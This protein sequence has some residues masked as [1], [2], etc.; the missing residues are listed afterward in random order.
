MRR[1]VPTAP[2]RVLDAP[3]LVDDYYLNLLDWSCANQVAIALEQSV[4]IWNAS[5]GSVANLM[6]CGSDNYV[7]SVRWSGDGAYLSIG[8]SD[9]DVQIW[10][11]DEQT[12]LRSMV[13]HQ[14]R[15]GVM[16][17]NNHL[18]SSG[19]RDGSIWNHDVRV[20]QHKVGE[21]RSH[22]A[23]VCGLEWRSDGSQLASGGND[24]LVNIWDA[25]S[26]APKLTKTNHRAAVKALAWCPW[27]LNLLATG[28]GSLD[29]HIHFW[30]STTGAR[31]N[32]IDTG[33]QV[34]SLKWSSVYKEIVSSHGF[35]DNHLTI[36]SYPTMTKNVEIAA[37]DSRV[38]H[39][40]ISPDGQTLATCAADENLK[41]WK[42][43]ENVGRK[44]QSAASSSI[45]AGKD[46]GKAMM[47]R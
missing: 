46:L 26:A 22:S 20:A 10:D 45:A 6:D 28:G 19:C 18:V 32:S 34:T 15:V 47:I 33:S 12:K 16:S 44:V 41:F 4:Y 23:E 1:K 21:F 5:S 9:G 25:R 40:A 13:G 36:W 7:S 8:L 42:I 43:F 37:H 3:G 39:A 2:D 35:P 31:V 17:W 27:Q 29:K 14:A 30:N 11:V 24:N 38:L